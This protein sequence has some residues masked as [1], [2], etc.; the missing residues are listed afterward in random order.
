MVGSNRLDSTPSCHGST[1]QTELFVLQ[2]IA[3]HG[4]YP[5]SHTPSTFID[6]RFVVQLCFEALN[7][8][9]SIKYIL[10]WSCTW[11]LWMNQTNPFV[12]DLASGSESTVCLSKTI[13]SLEKL[14]FK[15]LNLKL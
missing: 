12:H 4:Y 1:T 2:F 13:K 6:S 7:H 3:S 15:K 8:R 5:M 14:N 10:V 11:R 9:T